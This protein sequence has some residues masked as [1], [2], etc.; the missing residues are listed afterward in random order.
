MKS[1]YLILLTAVASLCLLLANPVVAQDG[2]FADFVTT[3]GDFRVEL[4]YQ[5][6]P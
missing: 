1:R 2:I 6:A 5:K 3:E 4:N